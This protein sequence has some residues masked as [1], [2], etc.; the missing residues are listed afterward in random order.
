MAAASRPRPSW[1]ADP[2]PAWCAVEHREDD[3][4]P[5]RVHDSVGRYV[6]VVLAES[7]GHAQVS[8]ELLVMLSR[9][10]DETAEWVFVGEPERDG[11]H[12]VLSRESAARVTQALATLLDD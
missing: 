4:P 8:A 7:Q 11:Q 12:L 5:D 10:C 1:Q 6:R 9:R 2:C 3:P